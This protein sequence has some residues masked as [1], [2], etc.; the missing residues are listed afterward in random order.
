MTPF[1]ESE[2]N[3]KHLGVPDKSIPLKMHTLT[4]TQCCL[5][6]DDLEK[7]CSL[8]I[9]GLYYEHVSSVQN[10]HMTA[11]VSQIQSLYGNARGSGVAKTTERAWLWKALTPR[12]QPI[13]CSIQNSG[14][15]AR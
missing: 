5:D 11:I 14:V 13:N 8:W 15:L 1:K 7:Q 9:G 3:T 2:I 12:F 6:K 10:L 4:S